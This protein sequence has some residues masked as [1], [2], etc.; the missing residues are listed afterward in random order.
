MTPPF[1]V[2]LAHPT[3]QLEFARGATGGPQPERRVIALS[4]GPTMT[5]GR[6]VAGV[7]VLPA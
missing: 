4:P 3:G 6:S 7:T 5:F 1:R 2:Y